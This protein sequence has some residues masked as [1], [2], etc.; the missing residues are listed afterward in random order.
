MILIAVPN[1]GAVPFPPLFTCDAV[2]EPLTPAIDLAVYC[3]VG[4]V[5]V[6]EKVIF[7]FLE[8]L[9]STAIVNEADP[10]PALQLVI[11][12]QAVALAA[13]GTVIFSNTQFEAL[14]ALVTFGIDTAVPAVAF[15]AVVVDDCTPITVPVAWFPIEIPVALGPVVVGMEIPRSVFKVATVTT[16]VVVPLIVFVIFLLVES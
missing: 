6:C 1:V 2:T 7:N 15:D 3:N 14:P 8:S 5:C 13:T 10:E 9:E 4:A 11:S 16:S 12:S